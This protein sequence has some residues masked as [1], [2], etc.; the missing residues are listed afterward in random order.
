MEELKNEDFT[1]RELNA[2]ELVR[3]NNETAAISTVEANE[4]DIFDLE[5]W[6]TKIFE[7]N[8]A[9][10]INDFSQIS[11]TLNELS[12]K[13]E[14]RDDII[15]DCLDPIENSDFFYYAISC[16]SVNN[17]KITYALIRFI[18][19]MVFVSS[20]F[21]EI[22]CKNGFLNQ[23]YA[24]FYQQMNSNS[25]Y[26]PP[27]IKYFFS[28]FG[29]ICADKPS[30]LFQMAQLGVLPFCEKVLLDYISDIDLVLS[31]I[32]SLEEM[33]SIFN[34]KES[35]QTFSYPQISSLFHTLKIILASLIIKKPDP[36]SQNAILSDQIQSENDSN[37][38]IEN[39]VVSE[40]T[41]IFEG[42]LSGNIGYDYGS[43]ISLDDRLKV[44]KSCFGVL[45]NFGNTYITTTILLNSSVPQ[46]CYEILDPQFPM[47]FTDKEMINI[48]K[49]NATLVLKYT[50]RHGPKQLLQKFIEEQID[51]G[52]LSLYIDPS[53]P[54][55]TTNILSVIGYILH[56]SQNAIFEA[57]ECD[58]FN[59]IFQLYDDAE[60]AVKSMIFHVITAGIINSV[61]SDATSVFLKTDIIDILVDG[62]DTNISDS[63][64]DIPKALNILAQCASS[65]GNEIYYMILPFIDECNNF[66][67]NDRL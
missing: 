4:P 38:Q 52:L 49:I 37:E 60:F 12:D 6:S 48:I 33:F 13:L 26:S 44:T 34:D 58:L 11:S 61:S 16:L 1:L 56:S 18:S 45:S 25:P 64:D 24:I 28:L 65:N 3:H 36:Q 43:T 27:I 23:I 50:F 41:N 55:V 5:F 46:F 9:C 17:D 54:Q 63:K 35:T 66:D 10:S 39:E 47:V 21:T 19:Y 51:I 31:I 40:N 53:Y 32:R 30:W 42:V 67:I 15:S 29:Y 59:K 8:N 2:F 62:I 22:I 14:K 7:F 57:I 20:D